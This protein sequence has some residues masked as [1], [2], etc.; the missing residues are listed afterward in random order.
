MRL[1]TKIA[2]SVAVAVFAQ[3]VQL[4]QKLQFSH[5]AVFVA[6][7]VLLASFFASSETKKPRAL[8]GLMCKLYFRLSC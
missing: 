5:I 4:Q 1:L 2:V 7:A 6:V 3:K 8:H